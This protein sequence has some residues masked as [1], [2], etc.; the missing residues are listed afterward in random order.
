MTLEEKAKQYAN[1]TYTHSKEAVEQAYIA[2]AKDMLK[3]KVN[4]TT[5]SDA[6]LRE[7][8]IMWHDLRKDPND[9]PP[10]MGL[11]SIEVYI[12]YAQKYPVVT[13]FAYYRFDK[14]V[15]ERN[16]NEKEITDVIAWK[17]IVLPKECEE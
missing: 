6:P 3:M 12:Q 8:G 14:H 16:E 9:L 11:G 2:G 7:N 1:S 4:V 13:D 10:K 5:I 15:W 17:E